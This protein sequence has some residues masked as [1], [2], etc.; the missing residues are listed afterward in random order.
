MEKNKESISIFT[1]LALMQQL[2]TFLRYIRDL[3][4]VYQNLLPRNIFIKKALV[5]KATNF[6]N[7]FSFSLNLN[8]ND[9]PERSSYLFPYVLTKKFGNNRTCDD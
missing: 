6:S 3:N 2:T 5:L 7:V 8:N 1:K 4:L 9:Q